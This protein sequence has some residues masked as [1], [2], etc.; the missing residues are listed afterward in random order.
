[1]YSRNGVILLA[2]TPIQSYTSI[3]G[4]STTVLYTCRRHPSSTS[5]EVRVYSTRCAAHWNFADDML[6]PLAL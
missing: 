4:K 2:K 6:Q 1:V 3:V 5:I